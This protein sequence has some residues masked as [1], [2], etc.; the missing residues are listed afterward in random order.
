MAYKTLNSIKQIVRILAIPFL[1]ILIFKI[2]LPYPAQA[3]SMTDIRIGLVDLY[4]DK[5]RIMVYNSRIA[6]GFCVNNSYSAE[7]EL[8]STTGFGF[9]PDKGT[10]YAD[11]NNYPSFQKAVSICGTYEA[12]GAKAFPV[13]AGTGCWKCYITAASYNNLANVNSGDLIIFFVVVAFFMIVGGKDDNS[14]KK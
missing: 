10:Y 1:C 14:K 9:T 3:A 12:Q 4:K 13:Y 6:L 5:S 8:D 2:C 7:I 11:I